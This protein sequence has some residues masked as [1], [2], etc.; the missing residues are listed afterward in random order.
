MSFSP[1]NML[2]EVGINRNI[3]NGNNANKGANNTI[4]GVNTYVYKE[5][6][7]NNI[8][9][10]G[11]EAI[12]YSKDGE[13]NQSIEYGKK[14]QE[15]EIYRMDKEKHRLSND[16]NN[17]MHDQNK[18]KEENFK[19]ITHFAKYLF[20]IAKKVAYIDGAA[21]GGGAPGDGGGTSGISCSTSGTTPNEELHKLL[22]K[23]LIYKLNKIL[24]S[25]INFNVLQYNE[26][27]NIKQEIEYACLKKSNITL[28]KIRLMLKKLEESNIN[29]KYILH[30]LLKLKQ[31]DDEN[32]NT[33]MTISRNVKVDAPHLHNPQQPHY[34]QQ[35]HNPVQPLNPL[36]D[37]INTDEQNKNKRSEHDNVNYISN[38]IHVQDET[39]VNPKRDV[40]HGN[41]TTNQNSNM[42]NHEGYKKLTIINKTEEGNKLE[43]PNDRTQRSGISNNGGVGSTN[44][45]LTV[46]GRDKDRKTERL[47]E[48]LTERQS[49]RGRN[50]NSILHR[51]NLI[52][53]SLYATIILNNKFHYLDIEESFLLKDLIYPLQGLNGEYIKYNKTEN[54]FFVHNRKISIGMHHI[55]N[56][57]SYVGILFKKLKMYV[58]HSGSNDSGKAS[59]LCYEDDHA[60][61]SSDDNINL[62]DVYCNNNDMINMHNGKNYMDNIYNSGHSGDKASYGVSNTYNNH[63]DDSR[64]HYPISGGKKH[65]EGMNINSGSSNCN[66]CEKCG[67]YDNCDNG[68]CN[69]IAR[70]RRKGSLVVDA[71]HQIIREYMNEYYKLLSYIESDLNE[72]IHKN[73]VYIGINKLYLLLQE[74]YK[75]LRVLVNVVDESLRNTGCRFLSFLYS[76]SQAYDY[77]EQKI[78]K[79]I[80]QKCIKPINEIL[81]Q[82]T[83]YGILKD[84][85]NETFISTNKTVTS[86][87]IWTY[88]FFLNFNNV[89]LFLSVNTAKKILLTGKSVYL[90]NLFGNN[91]NVVGASNMSS[92]LY[93]SSNDDAFKF[94]TALAANAICNVFPLAKEKNIVLLKCPSGG[95]GGA[96]LRGGSTYTTMGN[97]CN[98]VKYTNKH[99]ISRKRSNRGLKGSVH[100]SIKSPYSSSEDD[101]N[102]EDEPLLDDV[103][104]INDV[105]IYI[106]SID[107]YIKKISERKNKKLITLLIKKYELYEHLRAFRYFLLL[108]DGDLFETIFDN[109]K[110]DLYMNAEEL[111]RHYLNSKLD[112]CIKSSSL[113]TS[114]QNIIKKLTLEKFNIRR[115]DIGWDV[116]VFDFLVEKPL[117]IIFTKKIKSIYKSI[118]VL[119]IKIKKI[120]CELSNIWYLFTH[121]FKIINIVYYNSVF[122]YCNIIRNEMFHF[123]HNILSYFY[124]DIIDMNWSD[125]KK[126]LFSCNDLDQ[127]IQEHYNYITQIQFDLFLGSYNDLVV[128][129]CPFNESDDESRHAY[130]NSSLDADGSL[131]DLYAS[132]REHNGRYNGVGSDSGSGS[133]KDNH[134]DNDSEI[135][136]LNDGNNIRV[137]AVTTRERNRGF[138][139]ENRKNEPN[140][141]HICLNKILDIITRFIN[142]TSALISSVCEN[143]TEIKKLTEERKENKTNFDNDV[144]YIN[145]Y[146]NYNIIGEKTIKDIKMLLKYYRNYIYKF[147]CLLLSENKYIHAYSKNTKR[148]KLHS[149]RLL[150]A[151]LDFNLYYVNISKV[152]ETKNTKLNIS[153]QI[154]MMNK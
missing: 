113:F 79:K 83:E 103:F 114:N 28:N 99:D 112:L 154:K 49:G 42:S 94:H 135:N 45:M 2:N 111:K 46:R 146:I 38:N 138:S 86:E 117:D 27:E 50:D 20:F 33:I 122:I 29:Y 71:L 91:N 75:I 1:T 120:F 128:N 147:I 3:A 64:S 144:D 69:C 124:Y 37:G 70:P 102:P 18:K 16:G 93:S 95:A 73:T 137:S 121:L 123:V 139:K 106:D 19:S 59:S 133:G 41:L 110:T 105:N 98:K 125:F 90:L 6:Y 54:S 80:L 10:K 109:M 116:L 55:I 100:Y 148:D 88:K 36:S 76:K 119:L 145:N 60:A 7:A 65:M 134:N 21:L 32:R 97:I 52:N 66:K 87:Q 63:P 43:L 40:G 15:R 108:V 4:E 136:N 11:E 77:E 48:R 51:N 61:Y 57:I 150:A 126:R 17:N 129:S 153:K 84:K 131:S 81:K 78:Y 92:G 23:H 22:V 89:P 101:E 25:L 53:K 104:C 96:D 82:W 8:N 14:R 34:P 141:T 132:P 72:H 39:S 62:D 143:Y 31:Y 107:Y 35:L 140:E 142:L 47:T 5:N 9:V 118:N 151:R 68:K 149:L 74:S 85:Y 115:G 130:F 12:H 44:K 58:N 67:K 13:Y 127:L 26:N 24:S 30:I 152:V 56:N